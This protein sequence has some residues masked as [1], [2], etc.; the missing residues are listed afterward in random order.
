MKKLVLILTSTM[1]IPYLA[2]GGGI[3]TNTNQSATFTRTLVRDAS[4]SIDAV[5]YNPAGLTRL[6]DGFHFSLNNQTIWQTKN[7]TATYPLLS[8][9]PKDYKGEIFAPIFPSI[10]AAWT[11]EKIG[12]SFGFN[13][14]G[15]GGG[16]EYKDGLFTFEK[17][18]TLLVPTISNAL[19]PL[20]QN[21]LAAMGV[22]PMFRNVTGYNDSIYFKGSS[23]FF[24]YQLGFTYEINNMI[25]VAAGVRYVSAKNTYSGSISNITISAAPLNPALHGSYKPGDY[26][27]TISAATG[28]DLSAQAAFIDAQ[29]AD[30]EV[31]AEAKGSGF[32]PILGANLSL[33]DNKLDVG[34]KYEFKTK[35]DLNM[36]IIDGK[37]GGGVFVQDDTLHNDIPAMLSIGVDYNIIKNLKVS[38]GFHYYWDKK[39]D[40]G[41]SLDGEPVTNDLVMDKNYYELGIALEY[42]IKGKIFVSAGYLY[43]HTGVTEDYQEELSYSLSSS[44]VG[45]GVGIKITDN[46]MVNVGGGYSMDQDQTKTETDPVS[47]VPYTLEFKKNS[48]LVGIGVDFSF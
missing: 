8:E 29:T 11:K 43:N 44:T 20:D 13:P 3:I 30:R 35:L 21:I 23:I 15:G 10:Y 17:D 39:A 25:S 48:T 12:V 47:S 9:S 2:Y 28:I 34:L 33:L 31:D 41:K 7:V 36:D 24:G 40:Y 46:I 22:D 18:L 42:G 4:T 45:L 37:D 14:I 27:R 32:T 6:E 5:Y 19:T 38:A 1:L 26:F 16:A